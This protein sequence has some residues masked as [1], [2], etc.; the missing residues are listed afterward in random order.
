M[1]YRLP[2]FHFKS[3]FDVLYWINIPQTNYDSCLLVEQGK[4]AQKQYTIVEVLEYT[5]KLLQQVRS[6]PQTGE[7]LHF[8][9]TEAG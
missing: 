4:G 3:I 5:L 8:K 1:N 2:D 7:T 6:L 9:G